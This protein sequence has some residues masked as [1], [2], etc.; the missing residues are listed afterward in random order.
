MIDGI[1]KFTGK[2]PPLKDMSGE[3][4]YKVEQQGT[5]KGGIVAIITSYPLQC[6]YLYQSEGHFNKNWRLVHAG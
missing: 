2:R 5:T 4:L 1:Y 3:L 6:R